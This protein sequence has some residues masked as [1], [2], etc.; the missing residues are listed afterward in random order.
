MYMPID[1]V[2]H[3]TWENLIHGIAELTAVDFGVLLEC[4]FRGASLS[5]Q[6][7]LQILSSKL[8]V[9]D[10]FLQRLE[11]ELELV[12][13]LECPMMRQVDKSKWDHVKLLAGDLFDPVVLCHR[14]H[15]F[16]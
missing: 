3:F 12:F 14:V 6:V 13:V 2:S 8:E 1:D 10:L 11:L 16:D 5:H 7:L 15:S 4:C 9:L